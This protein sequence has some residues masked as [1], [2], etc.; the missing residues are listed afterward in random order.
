MN[1]EFN[2]INIIDILSIGTSFLFGLFFIVSKSK[3][4]IANLFLGLFLMSLSMEVLSTFLDNVKLDKFSYPSTGVITIPLLFLYII[5]TL[6]YQIRKRYMLLLLLPLIFVIFRIKSDY[7]YSGFDILFLIIILRIIAIHKMKLGDFHSNIENKTLSWI[8]TIVYTYLFF[9]LF[10]GI[11]DIITYQNKMITMYFSQI[12]SI[13]T[14]LIIYWIGYKGFSQPEIFINTI[15]YNK[16]N[17]VNVNDSSLKNNTEEQFKN[18]TEII[19]REQLFL[20]ADIDLYTLSKQLNIKEKELT[21]LIKIHT[22]KNF[23]QFMNQFRI[24]K[25]KKLVSSKKVKH[26]SLL[27]LAL[28]SGFGSKSSFYRVFKLMEGIT[29]NQ[30]LKSIKKS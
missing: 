19:Q 26:M 16:N 11:E 24:E 15:D 27:G 10:W 17:I 21:K 20:N 23:Y 30:Y 7:I 29:P 8:K 4:N 13:M 28:E 9:Y 22:N 12:S 1:I 5:K 3:N 18:L 2:Y 6:N 14:L 25:F